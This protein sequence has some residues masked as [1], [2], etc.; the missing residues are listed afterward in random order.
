MY[1]PLKLRLV[2]TLFLLQVIVKFYGLKCSQ[3]VA[4]TAELAIIHWLIWWSHRDL[5]LIHNQAISW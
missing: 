4:Q 1:I 3:P 5:A 2:A